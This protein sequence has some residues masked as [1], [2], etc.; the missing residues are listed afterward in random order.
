MMELGRFI[1]GQGRAATVEIKRSLWPLVVAVSASHTSMP[2]NRPFNGFPSWVLDKQWL[3][4]L[5][6]IV[7]A[8]SR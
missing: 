5:L 2:A 7:L 6:K 1:A 4:S 8:S 3:A